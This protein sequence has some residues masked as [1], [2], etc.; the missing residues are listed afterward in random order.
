MRKIICN[1]FNLVPKED[2]IQL[3]ESHQELAQ[4]VRNLLWNVSKQQEKVSGNL[5]VIIPKV[6]PHKNDHITYKIKKTFLS[7]LK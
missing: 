3:K 4:N 5:S 2:M 7:R 1:L 6:Y